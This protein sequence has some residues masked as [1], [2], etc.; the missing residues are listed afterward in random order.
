VGI[1]PPPPYAN[2]GPLLQQY[3]SQCLQSLIKNFEDHHDAGMELPKPYGTEFDIDDLIWMDAETKTKAAADAIGSGGMSPDEAR[4]RYFGLGKVK[5]GDT[6]YL[7]QQ[8]FSLRALAERDEKDPFAK[9]AP[10]PTPALPPA[11]D[12][13]DEEMAM[14]ASFASRLHRKA[15]EAGLY[16]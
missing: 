1:G 14:A 10:A 16:A 2:V 4:K 3:Y 11:E 5:G 7:Q 8:Y 12:D 6:P 13:E 15:L 9:P